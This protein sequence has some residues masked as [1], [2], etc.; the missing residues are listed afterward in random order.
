MRQKIFYL[1]FIV[2]SLL[3]GSTLFADMQLSLA[4]NTASEPQYVF[5]ISKEKQAET[6]N[7][8]QSDTSLDWLKDFD[9]DSLKQ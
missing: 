5:N 6:L 4:N 9:M 2:G 3:I 1:Y 8:G 7:K